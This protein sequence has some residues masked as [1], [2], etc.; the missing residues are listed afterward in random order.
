MMRE[1]INH[2]L[3]ERSI[4]PQDFLK[5]L[6]AIILNQIKRL[7]NKREMPSMI[8]KETAQE[9]YR[10]P[11]DDHPLLGHIAIYSINLILL[12]VL[13][14]NEPFIFD[15]NQ[16]TTHE[17][18]ARPW[19]R[20]SH[21]WRSWFSLDNL[22]GV[23]AILLADRKES[24]ITVSA[25]KI[26]QVAESQNR[27]KTCLN[28]ALSLGDNITSGL[29]G[30]LLF[31]PSKDNQLDIDDIA[32]RLSSEKIDI[33]LQVITKRLFQLEV[34]IST[35][36]I[37][38]YVI[39]LEQ[40]L[41]TAL[42]YDKRQEL[43]HICL[44]LRRAVQRLKHDD[45]MKRQSS[46]EI[47]KVFFDVVDPRMVS[48]IAMLNPQAALLLWQFTKEVPNLKWKH[49]FGR[50]VLD[51]L[52]HNR[53][54]ME[55]M[56]R[57][58]DM[59]VA[60]LQLIREFCDADST[61]HYNPKMF[62]HEFFERLLDLRHLLELSQHN[63]EAALSLVELA[64]EL[65]GGRLSERYAEEFRER[66]LDSSHHFVKL[67][68]RNPAAALVWL[69]IVRKFSGKHFVERFD[70]NYLSSEFFE[71][72]IQ[73]HRLLELAEH[74]PKMALA[75][76]KIIRELAE[77]RFLPSG[78]FTQVIAAD[79]LIELCESDPNIALLWFQLVSDFADNR[80][81]ELFRAKFS[82]TA[83]FEDM[84]SPRRLCDMIERNPEATMSWMTVLGERIIEKHC[85]EF[86]ELFFENTNL[87]RLLLKKPAAFAVAL[88]L[89][90]IIRSSRTVEAI[91][92][93]ITSQ[94]RH[95]KVGQS[96]IETLP[97]SALPD[98]E[99]L[100]NESNNKELQSAICHL[101]EARAGRKGI[102]GWF[103]K[104]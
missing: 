3:K 43:E 65:G 48:E 24:Q 21:I 39:M 95:S 10:A 35:G 84:F 56:E 61:K 94:L 74:S 31:E 79:Y 28:V 27:L 64:W 101:N 16:I 70:K 68:E 38:E 58:P 62:H 89:A 23:T 63:P 103:F 6:D 8:R 71:R 57:A 66:K 37:R 2:I 78:F 83:F 32:K 80:V 98:I 54:P 72:M 15:E 44:S 52:A 100:V 92:E 91:V 40:A 1:W 69:Q 7:L 67:T 76:L 104:M 50:D 85:Q 46:R 29:I 73:P 41:K 4:S 90:R 47:Y 81:M 96:V 49:T 97:I 87:S 102:K 30:L 75:W 99:W 82:S 19:D 9:G 18:G 60:W 51:F 77:E 33:E 36:K 26:F 20:L 88:R 34:Y 17:D 93:S 5:S 55:M 86:I 45:S 53:H 14:C 25:K 13:V 22:N 11:F 42:R 12:R 59:W